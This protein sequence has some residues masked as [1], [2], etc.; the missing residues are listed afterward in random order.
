VIVGA[1]WAVAL[2]LAAPQ[3]PSPEAAEAF[4][5]G[6]V[7]LLAAGTPAQYRAAVEAF[8]RAIELRPT[9]ARAYQE[10]SEA[11]FLAGAPPGQGFFSVSDAK[12][13]EDSTDSLEKALEL[14]LENPMVLGN[15]GFS[16]FLQALESDDPSLFE[17]SLEFTTRAR[18]INPGDPTL[19]YNRGAALVGLGRADDARAAYEQAIRLTIYSDPEKQVLRADPAGEERY[20]AGALADLELLAAARPAMVDQVRGLK[21]LI[22]GSDTLD[23]VGVGETELEIPG[24]TIKAPG[25]EEAVVVFPAEVQ[26]TAVL[27]GFN[28]DTDVISQQWYFQG[29]ENLGWAA[30]PSVSGVVTPTKEVDEGYFVLRSYLASTFPPSCLASGTYRVE[31][32]ANGRLVGVGEGE[33]PRPE[34]VGYVAW[35]LNAALCRPV[36]WVRSDDV[37]PGWA[38]GYVGPQKDRGVFVFRYTP[39]RTEATFDLLDGTV[40]QVFDHL[41]PSQPTLD[42]A[43][44][45][46][47]DFFMG[48]NEPRKRWYDYDGG[49]VLAGAG[50]AND[51]AVIVALAWGPTDLFDEA[52]DLGLRVFDSFIEFESVTP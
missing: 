52:G 34:L 19:A 4:A 23:R 32:Y 11:Q 13:V 29:P 51:G 9:F 41:F 47:T 17:E 10:R 18:E 15:L 35:D 45:T 5:D 36:D 42:T 3:T 21:E 28:P 14:G 24:G 40:E 6:H 38:D 50:V 16:R 30:L 44:G 48:L 12:A 31:L 25:E 26:W 46:D 43:E 27:P 8:D 39:P 1:V 2:A 33:A 7:K 37:I 49:R 22:V 20:V